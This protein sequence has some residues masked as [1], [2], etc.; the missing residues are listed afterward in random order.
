MTSAAEAV[1]AG[2]VFAASFGFAQDRRLKTCRKQH[3]CK[4]PPVLLFVIPEGNL[5]FS[6]HRQERIRKRT[7]F[8]EGRFSLQMI[9]SGA[10]A[11][12]AGKALMARLKPCP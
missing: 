4:A 9:P 7:R 10:K 12:I 1:L 2:R 5:R 8:R 6:P 11:P 3:N